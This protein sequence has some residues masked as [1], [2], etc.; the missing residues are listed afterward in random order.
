MKKYI[1]ILFVF[2]FLLFFQSYSAQDT[3]SK[4]VD[5]LVNSQEFTFHA[6]RANP[7]NYD[8]IKVMNSMP[9]STSTRI[10]DL[11]GDYT[12][13][14]KDKM[15]DVVLPYFGRSFKANVGGDNSYRFTSKDYTLTKSQN[16]KGKWIIKIKPNDVNNVD[17]IIVE[18]YKNGKAFTSV[19]SNDR[20]PISYDGYISK[21]E[22]T[23]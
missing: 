4:T 10:L 21:N 23:K 22:E 20:Q 16:K 3:D 5:A 11:N 17:E 13:I 2:G 18:V 19:R 14:V 15:L 6:Q 7:T 8:V 1:S 9:N 12:I